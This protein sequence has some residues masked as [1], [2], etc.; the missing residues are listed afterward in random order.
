MESESAPDTGPKA[1]PDAPR[2]MRQWMHWEPTRD[3]RPFAFLILT[4]ARVTVGIGALLTAISGLMPW[5]EGT[6]PGRGGFEPAFFSGLGGAGDGIMLILLS[7][8]T[9]FF[10]L[11]ETPA[12]SRVRLV[13]V[14]P[15]VLA[16]FAGLTVIN[17]YRSALIEIAAWE[18]KGGQGSIALGLWLAAGGVVVMGIGLAVLLPGLVRWTRQSTDP[19]DLM[20]VSPR[21]VAE[22]IAG[23]AG[24]LA[25]GAVGI[26]FASSLTAV[27]V[28]GLIALGA[29]FGGLLG[30]YAG[31]WLVRVVADE[32]A[33]RGSSGRAP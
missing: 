28:I 9:A 7:L 15:Y 22:A 29:V 18:R 26:A 1:P 19:A 27:P 10:V 21:G 16:V 20:T 3:Q 33:G 4:P 23:L 31:S 13:H 25:G 17:G 2:D 32:I 11:H 14:I 6:V 8:G 24:I 12:T 5:A 30:A